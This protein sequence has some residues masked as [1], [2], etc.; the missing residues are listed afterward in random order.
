M[1]EYCVVELVYSGSLTEA[2]AMA[3]Q[4]LRVADCL[5]TDGKGKLF[6]LLNNTGPE[7]LEYLQDR[8]LT[9]GMEIRPVLDEEAAASEPHGRKA[10]LQLC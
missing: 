3:G 10:G 5:G 8:L 2:A 7:N 1:A 6:A 4:M 9:C